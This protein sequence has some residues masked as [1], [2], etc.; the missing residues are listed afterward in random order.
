MQVVNKVNEQLRG[1]PVLVHSGSIQTFLLHVCPT[2]LSP[3]GISLGQLLLK[4]R[5]R[6]DGGNSQDLAPGTTRA[7][8][9]CDPA[10]AQLLMISSDLSEA[11]LI[12]LLVYLSAVTVLC[13]YIVWLPRVPHWASWPHVFSSITLVTWIFLQARMSAALAALVR[14]CNPRRMLRLPW[15]CPSSRCRRA[16]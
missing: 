2:K 12:L 4:W 7:L 1:Q 14:A 3:T 10:I 8:M 16:C 11:C 6:P 15:T 5:R 13:S 9:V